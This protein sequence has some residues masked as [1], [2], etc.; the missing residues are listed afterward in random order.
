MASVQESWSPASSIVDPNRIV[1]DSSLVV[2]GNLITPGKCISARVLDLPN[3]RW[4]ELNVAKDVRDEE[5][6]AD[7]VARYIKNAKEPFNGLSPA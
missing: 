1:Q 4:Y 3:R 7:T 2:Y 6:I 5:W